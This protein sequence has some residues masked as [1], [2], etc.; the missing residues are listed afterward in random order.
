MI[1]FMVRLRFEVKDYERVTEML[2]ALTAASRQEPGCVSYIPH[3]VADDRA[4]VVI[5]EQYRDEAA[6]EE[7]RASPHFKQYA[8]GGMYQIMVDRKLENLIAVC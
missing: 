7:H 1:S 8:S 2:R 5:Y 6:L 3:F 4:T